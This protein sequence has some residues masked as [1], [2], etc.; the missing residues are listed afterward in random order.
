MKTLHLAIIIGSVGIGV[1]MI[2][3]SVDT[4]NHITIKEDYTGGGIITVSGEVNPIQPFEKVLIQ[5][6]YLNGQPYISSQVPLMDYSNSYSYQIDIKP[7]RYGT[8][9]FEVQATYA[10]KSA[11][12][13]FE[14]VENK[15]PSFRILPTS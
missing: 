10:G 6:R 8:Y 5:V 1:L 4:G 12:A 15:S 9:D 2:S 14:Y 13:G 3:L 7:M 11:Y